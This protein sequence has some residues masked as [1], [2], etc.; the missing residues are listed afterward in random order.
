M[1]GLVKYRVLLVPERQTVLIHPVPA[2]TRR[3][4]RRKMMHNMKIQVY[5]NHYKLFD[6][7][8]GATEYAHKLLQ[9]QD[10][11]AKRQYKFG[12]VDMKPKFWDWVRGSDAEVGRRLLNKNC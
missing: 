4:K 1:H 2:C 8:E 9:W 11:E 3:Y 7:F 6:D 5:Q 10:E 12:I